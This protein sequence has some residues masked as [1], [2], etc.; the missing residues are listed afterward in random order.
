MSEEN[1][2]E[3]VEIL[4]NDGRKHLIK[5]GEYLSYKNNKFITKNEK[6]EEVLNIYEVKESIK[7]K[8]KMIREEC[9]SHE[10]DG[11]GK[12]TKTKISIPKVTEFLTDEYNFKT[13]YVN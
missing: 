5:F 10:Y 9:I 2:I 13:I 7:D 6:G 1:K 12:I 3:P 4:G 11:N 8:L